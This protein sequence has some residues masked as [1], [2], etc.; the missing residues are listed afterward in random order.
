MYRSSFVA[1]V[2]YSSSNSLFSSIA[3]SFNSLDSNTSPHSLHSTYSE[4]SSRDT[5]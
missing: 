4:S 3:I 5:I 1:G 2:A